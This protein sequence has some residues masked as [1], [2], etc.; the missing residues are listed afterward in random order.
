M[1]N[2]AS[3]E[4]VPILFHY[5]NG[6]GLPSLSRSVAHYLMLVRV[7]FI[8]NRAHLIQA[9]LCEDPLQPVLDLSQPLALLFLQ[10]VCLL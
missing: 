7:V 5:S 9:V 1:T 4:L 2:G 10:V 6:A 8:P 3:V